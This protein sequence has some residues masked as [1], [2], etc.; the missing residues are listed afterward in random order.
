MALALSILYPSVDEHFRELTWKILEQTIRRNPHFDTVF[1]E[2]GDLIEL[3][4]VASLS[5]WKDLLEI[6]TAYS[7]PDTSFFE[8][9]PGSDIL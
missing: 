4:E 3:S 5:F 7:T 2:A 9:R 1:T 6:L 8:A